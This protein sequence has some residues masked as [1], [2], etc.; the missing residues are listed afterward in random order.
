MTV[1]FTSWKSQIEAQMAQNVTKALTEVGLMAEERTKM[2]INASG[3]IQTG[4]MQASVGSNVDAG[5]KS[6]AYGIG[7][8]YGLFQDQGTSR[9]I[10]PGNFIQNAFNNH[11]SEYVDKLK[12]TLSEGF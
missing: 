9:G 1:K 12:S 8:S 5:A 10:T 7:V 2:Y 3:R 6:V 11:Q 4:T